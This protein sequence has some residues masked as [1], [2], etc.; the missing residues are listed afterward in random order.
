MKTRFLLFL[1][2]FLGSTL[3]GQTIYLKTGPTF[4][5]LTWNNSMINKN[6]FNKGIVGFDAIIGVN[7][8]NFKYLCL[9]S[10]IGF[11][12][13]GGSQNVIMTNELGDSIATIKEI[14]KLNYLTINTTFNLKI[15]IIKFLEPYIV[16]GPRLDYLIRYKE[17]VVF[18]KQFEDVGKL[19]KISYGILLGCGINCTITKFRL[20]IAFDYYFNINKQVDF[21]SSSGVTNTIFDKTYAINALIGYKF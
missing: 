15:P 7:Y 17:N 5:K 14:L 10:N 20:G 8:L 2:I 16:A 3:T 21:V 9:S 11:I 19:S 4:S 18:L 6:T 12:Q 13:K 1:F